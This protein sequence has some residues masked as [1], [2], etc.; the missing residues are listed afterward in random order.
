MFVYSLVVLRSCIFMWGLMLKLHVKI[1]RVFNDGTLQMSFLS[2][3]LLFST[4]Y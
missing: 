3:P 4:L 1:N 2:A